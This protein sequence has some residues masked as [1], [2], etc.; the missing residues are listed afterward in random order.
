MNNINRLKDLAMG[1]KRDWGSCKNNLIVM[2]AIGAVIGT[3]AAFVVY[4]GSTTYGPK[5][6][7][8][9][10]IAEVVYM[11]A[12][13][14]TTT[15]VAVKADGSLGVVVASTNM[16]ASYVTVFQC[17]H[18]KFTIAR[19]D[20]WEKAVEGQTVIIHYREVY[21]GW[22]DRPKLVAYDFLNFT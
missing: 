12:T 6:T 16:Q 7:E 3:L 22:G 17:S 5:L 21:R 10:L 15:G 1:T 4:Y 8:E 2:L 11:P 20:I 18:G 9:A 14:G 13:H 19:K